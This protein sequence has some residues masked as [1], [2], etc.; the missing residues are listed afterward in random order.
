MAR[1]FG[2]FRDRLKK[3]SRNLSLNDKDIEWVQIAT[4]FSWSPARRDYQWL[5]PE[6][7]L[8]SFLNSE[9]P[10][11]DQDENVTQGDNDD[12]QI[13]GVDLGLANQ[14]AGED[15]EYMP[16]P[17]E[18]SSTP[19][20]EESLPDPKVNIQADLPHVDEYKLEINS[21]LQRR[22]IHID[23]E[24]ISLPDELRYHLQNYHERGRSSIDS[25]ELRARLQNFKKQ[26][27][28][29][30]EQFNTAS[31]AFHSFDEMRKELDE[32]AKKISRKG[33]PGKDKDYESFIVSSLDRLE[34]SMRDDGTA[35][36]KEAEPEPPPDEDM[37]GEAESTA[38][39]GYG[40]MFPN[41]PS[42]LAD[43]SWL[44]LPVDS[45]S[46]GEE[47]GVGN[48]GGF[49]QSKW[50]IFDAEPPQTL[51]DEFREI[52]EKKEDSTSIE[53]IGEEND[54][55]LKA[56]NTINSQGESHKI[57]EEDNNDLSEAEP[58]K[59]DSE[60]RGIH[61]NVNTREIHS[62]FRTD[63]HDDEANG[64]K[65]ALFKQKPD[66]LPSIPG[67]IDEESLT[68]DATSLSDLLLRLRHE[69][70]K[71]GQL[72]PNINIPKE[73][74]TSEVEEKS[75]HVEFPDQAVSAPLDTADDDQFIVSKGDDNRTEDKELDTDAPDETMEQRRAR[76]IEEERKKLY[77][78]IDKLEESNDRLAQDSKTSDEK[79]VDPPLFKAQ[80]IP[81]IER[82]PLESLFGDKLKGKDEEDDVAASSPGLST[83][84]ALSLMDYIDSSDLDEE[85]H[86]DEMESVDPVKEFESHEVS[87]SR[88][89]EVEITDESVSHV[90]ESDEEL[91][92]AEDAPVS[93]DPPV[94]TAPEQERIVHTFSE[95]F[96][97]L[98]QDHVE[99]DRVEL[100]RVELD[101]VEPDHVEPDRVEPERVEPE[102]VEPE[103][104]VLDSVEP[105]SVKSD[106]IQEG[107]VDDLYN[108]TLAP[109]A[110]LDH[111]AEPEVEADPLDIDSESHVDA[112]SNVKP[113]ELDLDVA[114]EQVD[115]EGVIIMDTG[116]SEN[117][118]EL[119]MPQPQKE[120]DVPISEEPTV[121]F[122]PEFPSIDEG[123]DENVVQERD[124]A[125]F[126]EVA[127]EQTTLTGVIESLS[128]AADEPI[129][130][131]KIARI[132]SEV[133][134]TKMP[135]EKEIQEEID[136]LN[137]DYQKQGRSF[138]IKLWGGGVRMVT[139]P[140]YAKFI[141]PLYHDNR[142]KKLSRT[143]ME[144]LSIIAYSQP[145]TKPEVDFVRGVDSDYAVRKL[146]ELGL[147]DIV[148]RS[149]SIGR[150]LLYGTSERFLDQFGL[151]ELEALPKLRE[152]EELLGDPAFKKERL[153]LLA[154]EGLDDD[155]ASGNTQATG[156]AQDKAVPE[157]IS[158]E[159]PGK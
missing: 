103:R 6:D 7:Y 12:T 132:Y 66:S 133:M 138:R 30:Y 116:S 154:L 26:V 121:S 157:Q 124:T 137:D 125:E 19:N 37:P 104:V 143:L 118:E 33:E 20:S 109:S 50:D 39:N 55:L 111:T 141:R 100:D 9:V 101:R 27:I 34:A 58:L 105:D 135:T 126:D 40:S 134:S 49:S 22:G 86:Q 127:A 112:E 91:I 8:S 31:G 73:S 96:A 155:P 52:D 88:G 59:E 69:G 80:E 17:Y 41:Q 145:T 18:Y 115:N 85:E 4:S 44:V 21:A 16:P 75:L 87:L 56:L 123:V 97:A 71:P 10:S 67:E 14:D 64:E 102:R 45:P 142:P 74:E 128:F 63:T 38:P 148:G 53:P 114:L 147:I 60:D 106:I 81:T 119:I 13:G 28:E 82:S 151:S 153:H 113:R 47:G 84:H 68:G 54:G 57:D 156:N 24:K 107:K 98:E 89:Y 11:S 3:R 15:S 76:Y 144:T 42:S 36:E 130:L 23:I 65:N 158:Q 90:P 131:K 149:E 32:S 159:E 72:E 110:F 62:L 51:K 77:S 108:E 92:K 99:L 29:S 120:K 48:L 139:H 79:P 122:Q 129:P 117:E 46:P 43:D 78:L 70:D 150:P 2:G 140:S 35:E 146:L 95:S 61:S 5:E 94:E 152:V 93:V 1:Y 83:E 25:Y 136:R